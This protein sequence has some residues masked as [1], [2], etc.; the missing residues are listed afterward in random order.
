MDQFWGKDFSGTPFVLFGPSHLIALAIILLVNVSLFFWRNPSQMAR[1]A[2]RYG[3]TAV[4]LLDELILHLWYISNGLWSAQKMLPFHLCAVMVYLT[5]AMLITRNQ[6]IYEICYLLGIVGALQA[7]LTPDNAPYNFPHWRFI[8]VFLSHGSIIAAAVYM[9]V[10]EKFR[11][12]WPAVVRTWIAA[13]LYAIPIFI[14][15]LL[16]GSDY[17]FINRKPDTPSLLDMLP[18]W[19]W[20]LI[21]MEI[22]LILFLLLVYS[23]F[24]IKDWRARVTTAQA[25]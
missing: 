19:P 10:I 13:H 2:M 18:A 11:P 3:L 15:N 17:L 21:P 8:S 1:K 20:Y 6:F 23:P 9:T 5:S 7:V 12:T 22:L 25:G 24:A 16:I 14:L 4:L